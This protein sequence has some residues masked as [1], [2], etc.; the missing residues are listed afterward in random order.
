MTVPV[1]VKVILRIVI[2]FYGNERRLTGN[3]ETSDINTFTSGDCDRTSSIRIPINVKASGVGI[4][5]RPST[6]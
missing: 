5:R 1:P 2:L 3:H 6:D 4:F